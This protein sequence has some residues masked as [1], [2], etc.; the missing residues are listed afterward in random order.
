MK[1]LTQMI[2]MTKGEYGTALG[3]GGTSEDPIEVSREYLVR[4]IVQ[5]RAD[6]DVALQGRAAA[7]KEIAR[8]RRNEAVIA[9]LTSRGG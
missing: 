8:L 1:K 5:L 3:V 9:L 4:L 2:V 6:R 7:E